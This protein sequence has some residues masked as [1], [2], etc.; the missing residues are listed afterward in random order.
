MEK[1]C[2]KL[3]WI[4]LLPLQSRVVPLEVQKWLS[5]KQENKNESV[6][7]D[8]IVFF[9]HFCADFEGRV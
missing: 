7:Q 2:R 1:A 8:E 4:Q 3:V 9:P 6:G 5:K